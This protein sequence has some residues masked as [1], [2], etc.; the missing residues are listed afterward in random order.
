MYVG[1]DTVSVRGSIGVL[2][3][4][5]SGLHMTMSTVNSSIWF[6]SALLPFAP[7]ETSY[8]GIFE[9]KFAIEGVEGA[10][11]Y[12]LE[13]RAN[14]RAK[15]CRKHYYAVFK[16]NATSRRFRGYDTRSQRKAVTEFLQRD[17][18]YAHLTCTP[19]R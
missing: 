14:R 7:D 10:H 13:G 1:Q 11:V 3:A 9:F 17:I 16:P 15:T 12:V 2:G 18:V 6:A 5:G 4:W 8:S 19:L